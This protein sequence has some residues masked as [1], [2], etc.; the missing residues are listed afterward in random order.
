MIFFVCVSSTLYIVQ[1]G[2]DQRNS[3]HETRKDVFIFRKLLFF[4]L[5]VCASLRSFL[6]FARDTIKSLPHFPS[7]IRI[8]YKI[9]SLF[10]PVNFCVADINALRIAWV[11]HMKIDGD[12]DNNDGNPE[13]EYKRGESKIKIRRKII[14]RRRTS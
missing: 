11:L 2:A 14:R 1:L 6:L 5:C 7:H 4:S 9:V 13:T 12:G 8:V 3:L 10:F